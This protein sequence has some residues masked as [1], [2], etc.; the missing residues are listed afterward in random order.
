MVPKYMK[1]SFLLR[2]FPGRESLRSL[3]VKYPQLD[4]SAQECFLAL[5]G[6]TGEI[7]AAVEV[8]MSRR[9]TSQGRFR[10]LMELES[11]PEKVLAAGRLAQA[12]RVTPATITGLLDGLQRDGQILRERCPKDR[13]AVRVKLTRR[14]ER[15]LA[16]LLPERLRRTSRLMAKLSETDR[17]DLVRLLE[18]V[19]GGLEEFSRS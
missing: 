11:A 3:A 15:F 18:A 7:M 9:R 19:S 1:P 8:Q 17:R 2:N 5:L 14:G 10:I 6:V 4:L 13:R 12:V 16:E